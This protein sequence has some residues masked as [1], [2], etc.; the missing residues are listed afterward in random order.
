[1]FD[2]QLHETNN[3]CG[4]A[5][6]QQEAGAIPKRYGHYGVAT[7]D[8]SLPP[9]R[10]IGIPIATFDGYRIPSRFSKDILALIQADGGAMDKTLRCI[11]GAG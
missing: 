7:A 3:G 6:P 4:A 10:N 8:I 2:P 1:L 9:K 5:G 11:N